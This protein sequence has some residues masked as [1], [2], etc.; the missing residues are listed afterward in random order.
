MN[1]FLVTEVLRMQSRTLIA[2]RQVNQLL[3]MCQLII[4]C[5]VTLKLIF[6]YMITGI[7][8]VS[9]LILKDNSLHISGFQ[10]KMKL[11][12]ALGEDWHVIMT[13]YT[14]GTLIKTALIRQ[15]T[16]DMIR[17]AKKVKVMA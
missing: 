6:L 1:D 17:A 11:K 16:T 7:W 2:K 4:E 3:E 13:K 12:D 5:M 14:T 8:D 9:E 15:D 10:N